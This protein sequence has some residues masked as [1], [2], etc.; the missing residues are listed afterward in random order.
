MVTDRAL[1]AFNKHTIQLQE[2]ENKI[3]HF[4]NIGGSGY[5][6]CG[7]QGGHCIYILLGGGCFI[8]LLFD[9][10][11]SWPQIVEPFNS[12]INTKRVGTLNFAYQLPSRRR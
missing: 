6:S 12:R 11:N 10:N 7:F 3:V 5:I 4:Y 8:C 9:C 1:K 2:Y